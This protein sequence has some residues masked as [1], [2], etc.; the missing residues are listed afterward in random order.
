MPNESI[1][2]VADLETWRARFPRGRAP[3]RLKRPSRLEAWRRAEGYTYE[4]LG[5]LLD[6]S[7]NSAWRYCRPLDDPNFVVPPPAIMEL[8]PHLTR[9]RVLPMHFYGGK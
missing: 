6:R 8:L 2:V 1:D 4:Q 9:R 5:E 3:D 7:R